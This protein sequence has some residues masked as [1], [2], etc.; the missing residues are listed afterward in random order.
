[1][2]WAFVWF[3]HMM[4]VITLKNGICQPSRSRSLIPIYKAGVRVTPVVRP[5]L[6]MVRYNNQE[7]AKMSEERHAE[8]EKQRQQ[9]LQLEKEKLLKRKEEGERLRKEREEYLAEQERLDE[10]GIKRRKK[11]PEEMEWWELKA[12]QQK[13][14]EEKRAQWKEKVKF[15]KEMRE[16]DKQNEAERKEVESEQA[17]MAAQLKLQQEK[18]EAEYQKHL[19]MRL[20]NAKYIEDFLIASDQEHHLSWLNT[21]SLTSRM[22]WGKPEIKL[23]VMIDGSRTDTSSVERLLKSLSGQIFSLSLSHTSTRSFW[24][25]ASLPPYLPIYIPPHLSIYLSIYLSQAFLISPAHN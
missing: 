10:A 2:A 18:E 21:L 19:K 7:A 17:A 24:L 20:E 14:R 16:R 11:K 12:M 5:D 23:F 13:E 1:M 9:R 25:S 8:F 3:W 4:M 22:S 6:Q 15:M